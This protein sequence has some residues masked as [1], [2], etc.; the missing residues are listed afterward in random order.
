MEVKNALDRIKK[1][2]KGKITKEDKQ[3]IKILLEFIEKEIKIDSEITEEILK[4]GEKQW[5]ISTQKEK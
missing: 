1:A 2:L 4:E 5:I 3:E